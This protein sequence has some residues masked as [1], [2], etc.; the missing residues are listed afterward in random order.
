MQSSIRAVMAVYYNINKYMNRKR[1]I[2]SDQ[3][4]LLKDIN[5]FH[6]QRISEYTK[7][8]CQKV[9]NDI[10]NHFYSYKDLALYIACEYLYEN[11]FSW[12]NVNDKNINRIKDLFSESRYFLDQQLI[13]ELN[14]KLN[15][16]KISEYFKLN[17]D[18]ISIIYNLITHEKHYISPLFF[19]KFEKIAIKNDVEF[20]PSKDYIY[21]IKT[22]KLIKTILT[23]KHF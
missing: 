16:E 11:K 21:F 17:H 12:Q 1:Y 5:E 14:E 10:E 18:G 3:I 20:I 6:Y 13:V 23:N 2:D 22:I 7:K 19:L 4:D 9:Y 8:H 15:F